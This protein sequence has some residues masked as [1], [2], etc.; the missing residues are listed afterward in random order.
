MTN[1]DIKRFGLILAIHA[2]IE[3]MKT[4]NRTRAQNKQSMAY[5]E[6]SFDEKA[7]ELRNIIYC[8]DDQL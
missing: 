1:T 8:H 2:E 5:S 6:V 7:A 4:A 3:G